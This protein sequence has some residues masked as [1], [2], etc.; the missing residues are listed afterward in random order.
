MPNSRIN[1]ILR[2]KKGFS[3]KLAC[4]CVKDEVSLLKVV[5]VD[6]FKGESLCEDFITAR[7]FVDEKM[8][9]LDESCRS[10][11]IVGVDC[12]DDGAAMFPNE[13]E[14]QQFHNMD[15]V[16]HD[17]D[18]VYDGDGGCDDIPRG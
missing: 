13:E 18:D 4:L 10:S 6:R 2:H 7:E 8:E 5:E 17:N 1:I 15:N 3:P 16:T 9:F 12:G 11:G 14:H